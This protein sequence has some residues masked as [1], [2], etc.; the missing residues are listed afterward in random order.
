EFGLCSSD[1]TASRKGPRR[2]DHSATPPRRRPPGTRPGVRHEDVAAADTAHASSA[3]GVHAGRSHDIACD[4]VP[5]TGETMFPPHE[6]PSSSK[7]AAHPAR[8][9]SGE[10]SRFPPAPSPPV[11]RPGE[12]TEVGTGRLTPQPPPGLVTD[13]H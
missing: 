7:H 13:C 2:E 5:G 12:D 10:T 6:P 8:R 1:L 3:S 11:R 4:V 9:P